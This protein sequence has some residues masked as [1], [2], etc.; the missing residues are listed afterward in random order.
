MI[1]SIKFIKFDPAKGRPIYRASEL[2]PLF[3]IDV[4]EYVLRVHLKF[5]AAPL[6][7]AV[8]VNEI[9]HNLYDGFGFPIAWQ[10]FSADDTQE[11]GEQ[12]YFPE[13]G[14]TRIDL[15]LKPRS[16]HPGINAEKN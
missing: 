6:S 1:L 11:T 10:A 2:D 13:I 15:T 4:D 12:L 8:A 7:R 5:K 14:E 9:I 16:P 3:S